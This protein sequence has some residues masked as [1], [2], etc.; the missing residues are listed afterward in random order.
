[1]YSWLIRPL[2]ADLQ[3]S[4]QVSTLVFVLDGELRNIPMSVL[5]DG[6]KYLAE[7]YSIAL[8]P[9]LQL[10][11]TTPLKPGKLKALTAGLTESVQGFSAL[12]N[13]NLELQ[14][15]GSAFTSAKKLLNQDFTNKNFETQFQESSLPVIHLATHAQFSSNPDETFILTWDG[16]VKVK[17]LD[18][19]LRADSQKRSPELLVLSACE[20]AQGDKRAALGLA[21]VAVRAGARST[22]ATLWKVADNTTAIFMGEFYRVAEDSHLPDSPKCVVK[23]L[24]PQSTDPLTLQVARRLFDTEAQTLYKLGNHPQIPRLLAHFEENHEFYLVQE[25][26][27]GEDLT[28]EMTPGV[29]LSES[30]VIALLQDILPVLEYVHQQLVIHRDIKPS[31]L[32]RRERDGKLVLIDFGAV[33][34]ISTQVVSAASASGYERTVAIGT[35]GYM[36]LE[37]LAGTPL[38]N[39]DIYALG[40]TAIQ[41]LTGKFPWELEPDLNTGQVLW[42]SEAQV[43]DA[44]AAI[45]DKMVRQSS[46]ER[47]QRAG[48]ILNDIRKIGDFLNSPT[49]T[50]LPVSPNAPTQLNLPVSATSPNTDKE[51]A[52]TPPPHKPAAFSKAKRR[53]ILVALAVA[54]VLLSSLE[55]THPAVR[56]F[57][58]LRQGNQF[59]DLNRP[60]EALNS[61]DKIIDDLNSEN[62]E[63]WKGKG[64]AMFLLER[65]E[66]A[67]A[68]YEKALQLQPNDPKTLINKGKVLYQLSRSREALDAHE[69]A[70]KS[71]P[72]N[73]DAWNGKGIALIGMGRWEDALAAFD[74]AREIKPQDPTVWQSKA[75]A[76]DYLQRRQEAANIYEEALAVYD[77]TVK[78]NPNNLTAWVDRGS[79]LM[80]LQRPQDALE[81]YENALKINPDS[82]TACLGKRTAL[83][84]LQRFDEALKSYD[85]ALEISPKD[86]QAWYNRGELLAQG[87]KNY[88]D[89][90]KYFDKALAIKPNLYSAW[91][92]KGLA[93]TSLTRYSEALV[94]FDKAKDISANDPWLWANRGFVQEKL[95]RNKDAIASYEKALQ[96]DP[97]FSPAIEALKPLRKI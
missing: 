19:L 54:G 95:Q 9:G 92:G 25:F 32:M 83:S 40:M 42:R 85:K 44:L 38:F 60:E 84:F 31:N 50:F 41:A 20:T 34:K 16:K 90:V 77:K 15:I 24:Q 71:E 43:S 39:S 65:Y 33:K 6:Q 63:A 87:L 64:N 5:H 73:A 61:F 47:Y 45:L 8:T 56:P 70:I 36:P 10:L 94:A 28:K 86:Y 79:V 62:A 91:L 2:E 27:L 11:E 14:K 75:L 78:S 67:L 69:Q 48:D 37:Q 96:I 35:R 58:Y 46:R 59:L 7:K 52:P 21:G 93:L 17:D 81:S 4:P 80:K 13:V 74:K 76:L 89:A 30:Y 12:P 82:H 1:V 53:N 29:Q 49:E 26:I 66:G 88:E 72:T 97:N 55:L 68:A 22:L 51:D 18:K 23:Q 57:Y 3:K